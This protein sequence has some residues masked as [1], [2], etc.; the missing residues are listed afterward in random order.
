MNFCWL[1]PSFAVPPSLDCKLPRAGPRPTSVQMW[2]GW[3]VRA[4]LL[5]VS[6]SGGA[7]WPQPAPR[8]PPLSPSVHLSDRPQHLPAPEPSSTSGSARTELLLSPWSPVPRLTLL[9]NQPRPCS[10]WPLSFAQL[11]FHWACLEAIH[12]A[13]TGRQW[14]PHTPRVTT[15]RG[16]GDHTTGLRPASSWLSGPLSAD[17]G[18]VL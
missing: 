5:C 7:A 18:K 1:S 10:P 17:Q 11:G 12:P 8:L 9:P 6:G 16:D 4:R 15:A 14:Q 13:G 3:S 2:E